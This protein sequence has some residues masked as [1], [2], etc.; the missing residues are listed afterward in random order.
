VRSQ[1]HVRFFRIRRLIIRRVYTLEAAF[2]EKTSSWR[3]SRVEYASECLYSYFYPVKGFALN[4]TRGLPHI[5]LGLSMR[6]WK[7]IRTFS[8]LALINFIILPGGVFL[9]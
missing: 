3:S 2:H 7:A 1:F 9:M 5:H 4:D 6:Q 8:N